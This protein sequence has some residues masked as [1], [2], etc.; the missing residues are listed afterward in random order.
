[1]T[2][3]SRFVRRTDLRNNP[4]FEQVSSQ[5]GK[6]LGGRD[7]GDGRTDPCHGVSHGDTDRNPAVRVARDTN[8][9]WSNDSAS[10]GPEIPLQAADG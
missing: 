10:D 7:Q 4:R 3:G 5:L 1:M 6:T 8:E 2:L 9:I